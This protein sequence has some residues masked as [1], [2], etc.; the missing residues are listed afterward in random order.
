MGKRVTAVLAA[1]AVT[2]GFGV[3]ASGP[4]QAAEPDVT[5]FYCQMSDPA[6]HSTGII[7]LWYSGNLVGQGCSAY[8]GHGDHLDFSFGAGDEASDGHYVY[9]QRNLSWVND[10]WVTIVEDHSG[11]GGDDAWTWKKYAVGSGTLSY[12]VCRSG[13]PNPCA[14]VLTVS[15]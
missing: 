14:T 9:G 7:G 10:G 2:F 1:V 13:S 6:Y 5:G 8:K 15:F 4:A 3:C 12:R 11:A